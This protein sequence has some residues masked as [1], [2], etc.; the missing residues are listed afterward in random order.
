MLCATLSDRG[1]GH[2]NVYMENGVVLGEC[3]HSWVRQ[4]AGLAT[5]VFDLPV[6][7]P[8]GTAHA[9]R[10]TNIVRNS[11]RRRKKTACDSHCHTGSQELECLRRK[12]ASKRPTSST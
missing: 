8:G 9:F 3:Q 10:K 6:G 11:S 2:G 5:L 1:V 7:T 4:R 12:Q